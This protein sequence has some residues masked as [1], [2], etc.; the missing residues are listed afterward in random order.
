MLLGFLLLIGACGGGSESAVRTDSGGNG[1]TAVA[2][3]VVTGVAAAGSPILGQ[4]TLKDKN[5]IQRGPVDVDM[6]GRF[7]FEVNDLTPPFVLKAVGHVGG[8]SILLY[9]IV[10]KAGQANINP[11]THLILAVA[12][13]IYPADVFGADGKAPAIEAISD[14]AL[15]DALTGVKTLLQPLLDKYG[16]TDFDPISG[17]Y[18]ANPDNRLDAMLDVVQFLVTTG[19]S[20]TITN[21][22]TDTVIGGGDLA[23]ICA[24]K[25]YKNDAPAASSLT[26]VR[27]LTA[28]VAALGAVMGS[29]SALTTQALEDFFV[30]DPR[31]GTSASHTRTEDIESIP[32]IFG[33]G[34][35]NTRGALKQLRNIRMVRDITD[36]YFVERGVSKVYVINYDFVYNNEVVTG[37]NVIFAK[38]TV[39]GKWKFIGDSDQFVDTG[40]SNYGAYVV[41]TATINYGLEGTM[42][43]DDPIEPSADNPDEDK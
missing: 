2:P 20:L 4:V 21:R 36:Y 14:E 7:S 39:S 12:A 38:E 43:I 13:G 35:T 19:G 41:Y 40:G 15:G 3:S 30:P 5:G 27:E 34:G 18:E 8:D 29:G 16:I 6:N 10:T 24:I 25:L 26:D 9:S 42:V 32:A 1:Q 31:Y 33:P 17:D 22:L 23:D 37:S 28:R 11:L